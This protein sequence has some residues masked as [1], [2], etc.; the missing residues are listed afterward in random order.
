MDVVILRQL[1]ATRAQLP[2][3]LEHNDSFLLAKNPNIKN[4]EGIEIKSLSVL[5]KD[6]I[7]QKPAVFSCLK[8]PSDL[9][10]ELFEIFRF[11]KVLTDDHLL[12]L[13]GSKIDKVNLAGLNIT[14]RALIN[15]SNAVP[16]LQS[17]S[18]TG[19]P[20]VTLDGKIPL[21][22]KFHFPRIYILIFKNI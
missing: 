22:F 18:I 16:K 17:I 15:L 13:Q 2:P 14:D 6:L 7:K 20:Y 12:M 4:K 9:R 8:L 21:I 5:C 1:L 10:L 19:C 11:G 3:T